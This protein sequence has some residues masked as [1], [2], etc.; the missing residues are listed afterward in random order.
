[1]MKNI[2]FD[3]EEVYLDDLEKDLKYLET[4]CKTF[5]GK[6][7]D[8]RPERDCIDYLGMDIDEMTLND[9]YQ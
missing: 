3:C 2:E 5:M 9:E 1:M 7:S 6:L 4:F 8:I